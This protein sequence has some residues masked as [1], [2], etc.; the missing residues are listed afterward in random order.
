MKKYGQA[1]INLHDLGDWLGIQE[2]KAIKNLRCT[3]R[4]LARQGE[5]EKIG[6]NLYRAVPKQAG[7]PSKQEVMWR[8]LRARRSVT[9]ADLEELAGVERSYGLEFLR[10]LVK[11]GVA[12]KSG[13]DKAPGLPKYRL[14]SDPVELPKN[15]TKAEYLRSHREVKKKAL[16]ALDAVFAAVAEARMAIAGLEE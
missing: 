16:A 13:D 6:I 2:R 4:D 9:V 15:E 8:V 11:R 10:N 3:L 14:A 12:V 1:E 5:V 7:Q